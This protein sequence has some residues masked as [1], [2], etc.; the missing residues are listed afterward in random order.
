VPR[1]TRVD[2]MDPAEILTR[3]APPPDATIKYGPGLD[4]IADVRRPSGGGPRGPSA[5]SGQPLV[6][7]LHGGFGERPLTAS[8]SGRWQRPSRP[9]ATSCA[10]RSAGSA[11]PA[12]AGQG[13]ST[14][15]RRRW[16]GCR[17][18]SQPL[19]RAPAPPG[20]YCSLA[21]PQAPIWPSGR[22]GGTCLPRDGPWRADAGSRHR[23]GGG[24]RAGQRS[25]GLPPPATR[26]WHGR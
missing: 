26:R 11:R 1:S 6:V 14:M 13:L 9:R 12:A 2:A 22:R 8:T 10:C 18:W 4:H 16:A 15:S 7:V 21:I 24:A 17:P 5:G 3:P 19:R 25:G 23:W 20:G